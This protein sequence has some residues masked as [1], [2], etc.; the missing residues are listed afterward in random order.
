MVIEDNALDSVGEGS[1]FTCFIMHF[2]AFYCILPFGDIFSDFSIFGGLK[3]RGKIP[4]TYL[5]LCTPYPILLIHKITIFS[6][7]G[8]K[9]HGGI[10]CPNLSLYTPYPT[11]YL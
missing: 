6:M 5:P 3:K 10:A 1:H 4:R 9:K 8:L 11:L 7:D 2:H